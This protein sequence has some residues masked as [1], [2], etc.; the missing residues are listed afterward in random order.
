MLNREQLIDLYRTHREQ[1]IL[2]VYVDGEGH[3]PAERRAWALELEQGFSKERA[4]L[5]AE[6][7][8]E[9]EAFDRA[10]ATV[11]GQLARFGAFL[12]ARGWVGFA[13]AEAL[14]YGEELAV[15][16]PHLVRWERGLRAA[17]YVRALKQDRMVAVALVDSRKARVF[18]YRN[19]EIAERVDLVADADIGDLSDVNQSKRATI[20]TGSR[21]ETATDVAQRALEV[22]AARMRSRLAVVIEELAGPGGFVV[23]GGTAEAESALAHELAHLG[24]RVVIRGSLHLA[25]TE[26]EVRDVVEA[27]ASELT[28]TQ[29]GELLGVVFDLA[30]SGGKGA[31]GIPACEDALR[32]ARVETLLITRSFRERHPDRAD[33]YVGTAFEQGALVEELS[34]AH[35]GRLDDEAEGVAARLRYIA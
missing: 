30:R 4:R 18:T 5:E 16:M 35:A 3:D 15:P 21:G 28:D 31:L 24:S 23:L 29:Q 8:G 9:V 19:G 27:A 2:S 25:M 17:P 33:H 22:S 34:G 12:P 10:R 7:P 26:A 14:A 1:N 32:G 13:T 11:E 6:A 20:H